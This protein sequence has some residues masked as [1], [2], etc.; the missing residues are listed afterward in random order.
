[1]LMVRLMIAAAL[2]AQPM[3]AS[4]DAVSVVE[5]FHSALR[6][7]DAGAAAAL[8]ADDALIFEEGNAERSKAE[9]AHSH[10]QADIAF[11]GS[12][13]SSTTKRESKSVG[14]LAWVASEGKLT[15]TY[16]NRPVD[17]SSTETMVLRRTERGWKIVHIHWSSASRP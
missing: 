15:G 3:P 10:L 1:M 12:V 11:L 2:A 8:L 4:S 14:D 16:K 17:R 9:Y 5:A 7:G 6:S 13:S